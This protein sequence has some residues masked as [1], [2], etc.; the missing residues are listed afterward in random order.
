MVIMMASIKSLIIENGNWY[1]I[2]PG[3]F[4]LSLRSDVIVDL[5]DSFSVS[6]FSIVAFATLNLDRASAISY[7]NDG[8]F[9]E[10]VFV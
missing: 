10:V 1:S 9:D 8:G 6:I 4:S 2:S 5:V 3:N 7:F